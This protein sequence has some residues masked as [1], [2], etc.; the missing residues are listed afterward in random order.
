L[1]SYLVIFILFYV[2]RVTRTGVI[3]RKNT[4]KIGISAFIAFD[5]ALLYQGVRVCTGIYMPG[6]F[7]DFK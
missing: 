1:K 5:G 7:P 3:T 4:K 6:G 2:A